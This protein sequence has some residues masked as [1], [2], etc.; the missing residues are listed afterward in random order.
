MTEPLA[1][2]RSGA[3]GRRAEQPAPWGIA[4]SALLPD[5]PDRARCQTPRAPG[6]SWL[7]RSTVA[8]RHRDHGAGAETLGARGPYPFPMP[9]FWG[10]Q[11]DWLLQREECR[12]EQECEGEAGRS[13]GSG[14]R[15]WG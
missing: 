5:G 13:A 2:P 6:L 4:F 8:A 11:G 15:L 10:W 7:T 12:G 1:P 9:S 3:P 14:Q